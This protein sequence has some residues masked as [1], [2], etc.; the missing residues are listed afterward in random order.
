MRYR[1]KGKS[2][3]MRR[4]WQ[5]PVALERDRRVIVTSRLVET[6]RYRAHR[7]T[8][9]RVA[10]PRLSNNRYGDLK[11]GKSSVW[12]QEHEKRLV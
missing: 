9:F 3:Y 4:G 7:Q 6:A 11:S 8:T 12:S 1:G 10:R 5:V 2:K